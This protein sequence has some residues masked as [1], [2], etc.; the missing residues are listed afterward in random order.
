MGEVRLTNSLNRSRLLCFPA[1]QHRLGARAG[2]ILG[3]MDVSDYYQISLFSEAENVAVFNPFCL[4]IQTIT[5]FTII[6][7]ACNYVQFS[8]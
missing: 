5:F 2:L 7:L 4:L 6:R 3:F 1:P 8:A